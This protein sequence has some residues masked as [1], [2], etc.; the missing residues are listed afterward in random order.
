MTMNYRSSGQNWD[1]HFHHWLQKE[2]EFSMKDYNTKTGR[3]LMGSF[4]FVL[5]LMDEVHEYRVRAAIH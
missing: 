4:E 1:H 3:H 5:N 2:I